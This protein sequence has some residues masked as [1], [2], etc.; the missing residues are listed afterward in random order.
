MKRIFRFGGI[1]NTCDTPVMINEFVKK[2]WA[3]PGSPVADH[4]L[5]VP[6][7]AQHAIPCWKIWKYLSFTEGVQSWSPKVGHVRLLKKST[8][9]VISF[10]NYPIVCSSQ[11]QWWSFQVA[12]VCGEWY[13]VCFTK[14]TENISMF[15]IDLDF[16]YAIITLHFLLQHS[17]LFSRCRNNSLLEGCGRWWKEPWI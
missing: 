11:R 4:T 3:A 8:S 5:A 7:A 10:V 15:L 2:H 13:L 12:L 16:L 14:H 9:D 1:M 17:Q 6:G